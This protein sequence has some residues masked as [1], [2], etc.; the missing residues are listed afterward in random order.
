MG[1]IVLTI[2]HMVIIL[3]FMNCTA[4][5]SMFKGRSAALAMVP[6]MLR[7]KTSDVGHCR[8]SCANTH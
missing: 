7:Q 8:L 3:S 1:I 2:V 6:K 4:S 5:S